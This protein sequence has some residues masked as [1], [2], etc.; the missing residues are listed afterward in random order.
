MIVLV[1]TAVLADGDLR[2]VLLVAA[3]LAGGPVILPLTA[4]LLISLTADWGENEAARPMPRRLAQRI[5]LA[6]AGVLAA[7]AIGWYGLAPGVASYQIG[8]ALIL[9]ALGVVMWWL[10]RHTP[11]RAQWA[12]A[13]VVA[14]VGPIGYLIFGGSDWWAAY[15]LTV[16]PLAVLVLARVPR[17]PTPPTRSSVPGWIDGPW[18]PP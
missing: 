4:V 1:V 7:I 2:T 11:R 12:L 14:P 6:L 17:S 8:T 13:V 3:V 10:H 18:G 5:C 15:G 9:P 16:L